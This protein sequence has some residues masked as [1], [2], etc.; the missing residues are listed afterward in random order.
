MFITIVVWSPFVLM[1]Q[2]DGTAGGAVVLSVDAELDW[3]YRQEERPSAH[4]LQSAR[5]GWRTVLDYCDEYELPATWAIVGHLFQDTC[6][7]THADHPAPTGWF[8][9]AR[10]DASERAEFRCAPRL[11]REVSIADVDHDIGT[12]TYSNV[13]FGDDAVGE[14]LATCELVAALEAAADVSCEMTSLTCPN[15][16]V[17]H[18]KTLT[19]W[20]FTCYRSVHPGRS[21]R[22]ETSGTNVGSSP[23]PPP[24]L[25]NPYVDAYG[26]VNIPPSLHLYGFAPIAKRTKGDGAADP[27]VR[28]ARRGVERAIRDGGVFHVWFRPRDVV[29]DRHVERLRA[30]FEY[31]DRRRSETDLTVATMA[32]LA[33]TIREEQSM[34]PR[35]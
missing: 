6:D 9:C 28:Q 14:N 11:V 18:L 21:P 3:G 2:R 19:E 8:Q 10:D 23:L 25:S 35:R 30:V 16:N 31:V 24:P 33:G 32:E 15:D 4:H 26:L 29:T 13:E 22:P 12:H 34:T 5:S 1:P 7:G 27:V 20:G 17:G